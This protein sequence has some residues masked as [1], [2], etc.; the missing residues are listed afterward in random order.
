MVV[1]E[2]FVPRL[3]DTVVLFPTLHL[4]NSAWSRAN[5]PRQPDPALRHHPLRTPKSITRQVL[6]HPVWNFLPSQASRS[7]VRG[8]PWPPSTL[9]CLRP[10]PHLCH[11]Q[12]L[13]SS[14]SSGPN[15]APDEIRTS[16]SG[17]PFN[18]RRRKR[19]TLR[20]TKPRRR[21]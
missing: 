4:Q 12:Q 13:A 5:T 17:L 7:F 20:A 11:C 3:C 18:K 19:P 8:S 21:L 1:C 14:N 10:K 15:A 2:D 9:I 16:T 6:P